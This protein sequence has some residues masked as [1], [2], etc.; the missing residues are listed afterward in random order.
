VD[1]PK[2]TR[3]TVRPWEAAEL[4]RFLDHTARDP[5]GAF[6]GVAAF[7]GL[8][9][10]ELLGLR[11]DDIDLD[12]SR[13]TVRQQIVQVGH[14]T[15]IGPVKT[16][17]GQDRV[18]D[19]DPVTIG[20]LLTHRLRQEHQRALWAEAW[21]DTGHVFTKGDGTPLHPET[22]TKRFRELS[23]AAGLRPIRLH[24][25]RHG[26]ASLM[27]A[28][29]VPIAWSAN[30]SGT[31]RS[32]SP[33]TPTPTSSKAS[34]SRQQPPQPRSSPAATTEP[35]MNPARRRTRRAGGRG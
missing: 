15:H 13:L 30:D 23:D 7:T 34:G 22:V 11:W 24:D 14:A 19:L 27:L 3:P 12:R 35:K 5:L 2:A 16:S 33:P 6:Y 1:L 21:V 28:A 18:V 32:P 4:G 31:A 29:G 10:G 8:R 25:L 17:S 26:Q 9:R 20:A